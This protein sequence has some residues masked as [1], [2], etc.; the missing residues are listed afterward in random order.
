M[1]VFKL[2]MVAI[3][4]GLLTQGQSY[5]PLSG[6]TLT[7]NLSV[8]TSSNDVNINLFK[9][10]GSAGTANYIY[11]G[12]HSLPFQIFNSTSG[13]FNNRKIEIGVLDNGTAVLQ[14]NA[15]G[16]GYFPIHLNPVAGGVLIGNGN[17]MTT[18]YTLQVGGTSYF[19][20]TLSGN[21]ATFTG[22]I[23]IGT[24]NP[25]YIIE[26]R[27]HI[28]A[29]G[30]TGTGL[31][32]LHTSRG[33][34]AFSN[35][36][37]DPNHSIYNNGVNIDGE[38]SWDGM[39]MNVYAGLSIRVGNANGAIPN[40]AMYINSS[41]NIG[42]GTTSPSNMLDVY[43]S[44][45][46][47]TIRVISG[48][49]GAWLKAQSTNSYY[50]GVQLIGNNG[51]QNWSAGMTQGN[52]NYTISGSIDGS[53]NRYFTITYN[54]NVLIGKSSQTNTNY[55]L[56]VAGNI[57]ANKLVVNTT[58]ADFVFAKKYHLIPLNEL[59]KY[60]QQNKHLP[61]IEPAKRMSEEGVDVGK[62]ETKLLQ[63]IEELTLYLIEMKK[64]VNSLEVENNQ[65]KQ[66]IKFLKSK[67]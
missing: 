37:T 46:D 5:L 50:A 41:G 12:Q 43:S 44:S 24:T 6:G 7:G 61:G 26:T 13:I 35:T 1:K 3:L 4:T 45:N 63:K 8:G 11:V 14:A 54:G 10:I 52:S 9:K 38:G 67:K 30:A 60:I 15:A 56:D 28:S 53:A 18:S 34:L 49:A 51:S 59:E 57:R 23:G 22:N 58:G 20:G 39:K 65:I 31:Y 16:E 66:Q 29:G 32:N 36:A 27:G 25:Q 48:N 2:L 33:R 55:I 19:G 42:I 64:Q 62:N 17:T 21:S 47:P 40:T